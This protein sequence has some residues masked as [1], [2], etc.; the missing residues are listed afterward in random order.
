[1]YDIATQ[2][3]D[4]FVRAEADI[5]AATRVLS[6]NKV[7]AGE[8]PAFDVGTLVRDIELAPVPDKA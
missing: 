6:L 4:L 5:L 8:G 2:T 1:M 3:L 7:A